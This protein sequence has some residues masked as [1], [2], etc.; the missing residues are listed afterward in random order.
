MHPASLGK[1]GEVPEILRMQS[2]LKSLGGGGPT[3]NGFAALNVFGTWHVQY[4]GRFFAEDNGKKEKFI[5][6]SND[7]N[8]DRFKVI[9]K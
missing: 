8:G 4:P 6:L 1:P 7:A 3:P 2:Y 9:L 5:L